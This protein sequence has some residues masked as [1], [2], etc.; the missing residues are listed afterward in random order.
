MGGCTCLYMITFVPLFFPNLKVMLASQLDIFQFFW[1]EEPLWGSK[2]QIKNN[3]K[4][5]TQTDLITEISLKLGKHPAKQGKT[6]QKY[7]GTPQYRFYLYYTYTY[8]DVH[9]C[10]HAQESRSLGMLWPQA[11]RGGGVSPHERDLILITSWKS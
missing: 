10:V 5:N 9:V 7:K 2:R 3:G 1:V 6:H 8:A 4:S 11:T